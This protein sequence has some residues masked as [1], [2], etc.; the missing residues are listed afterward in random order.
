[1]EEL[2]RQYR[3]LFPILRAKCARLLGDVA[4]AE[5]VAQETFVR[6]WKAGQSDRPV[7]EVL[8]W[9]HTTATRLAIDRL[10]QRKLRLAVPLD[11]VAVT[12][13]A[14]LRLVLRELARGVPE[15]QLTAVLLH[16]V[17]GVPQ[18]EIAQSLGCTARTVRRWLADFDA[19]H[20]EAS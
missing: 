16:R 14:H 1:M 15:D 11:D 8:A 17:D 2:D 6:L 3:R 18:E 4:E 9:S 5:E 12:R 20:S 10:R 13:Q 7:R 19:H